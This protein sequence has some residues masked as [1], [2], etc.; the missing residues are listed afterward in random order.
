MATKNLNLGIV[1]VSRGEFNSTTIYYKDNIVQYKRGSYQVVSE[2]PIIGVPPTNDKN[3]VNPGWTLFAGTLDAQDVVNQVKDQETKSI[4]AV[5]DR[6]AEILAKSDAAEVSFNNTGTS[7]SG[8]N[9]QNALKETDNKLSE[10]ES[11][12]IY[13]VTANNDGTT[14]SSL[15]ALLSSENLSTLIPTSVRHGGMS[16]SFVQ[17][18]DNK[19]VQYFL[20][21]NVWSD[22]EADWQKL[23]LEEDVSQEVK[24]NYINLI[25][26]EQVGL[27]QS[28]TDITDSVSGYYDESGVFI[29]S[30]AFSSQKVTIDHSK[31]YYLTYNLVGASYKI[32]S[33][34][35][36][37]SNDNVIATQKLS[38][39]YNSKYL[40]KFP[41]SVAK[42]AT[43]HIP[44]NFRIYE[45]LVMD[46]LVDGLITD[47]KTNFFKSG[48]NLINPETVHDKVYSTN[49][50]YY[51]N[52]DY[53][54]SDYI[55]VE[56]NTEY[57]W[58]NFTYD[59]TYAR[60]LT[61]FDENK[62]VIS[63]VSVTSPATSPSGAKYAII[64]MYRV[65]D[66]EQPFG[67]LY[68]GKVN[69]TEFV[70]FWLKIPV[71]LIDFSHG[72]FQI[73]TNEIADGAITQEKLSTAVHINPSP[74]R[75][76]VLSS[77]VQTV[78]ANGTI[79]TPSIFGFKNISIIAHIDSTFNE[80]VLGGGK[81]SFYQV[82]FKIDG[83]NVQM[84][85]G[86][87]ATVQWTEAHGL[88]FGSHT[89]ICITTY[90][91]GTDKI[92][93]YNNE[94]EFWSHS[95]NYG[96]SG[97]IPYLT[98]NGNSAIDAELRFEMRDIN[99]KIWLFGDSY[100]SYDSD[101]RWPY[102][103]NADGFIENLISSLGGLSSSGAI[104]SFTNLLS[105]GARPSFAVWCMGMNDGSDSGN[106]PASIWLNNIQNFL[107][108]CENYGIT[109]ILATVPTVPNI[110][111]AG[112]TSWVKNSGCRY[113]DFA[114]AV[115][116]SGATTWKNWGTEKAMLS[117]DEVH[118]TAYGAKA[119]YQQAIRDFPEIMVTC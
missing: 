11:E 70:P 72:G 104:Q 55:E 43:S 117:S 32:S 60:F 88:T 89:L 17:S 58:K 8:T 9:V 84:L 110:N 91:S 38:E 44:N 40:L 103:M 85:I 21:K 93:I 5:A 75:F 20:T 14:F 26:I 94:G 111:H 27:I 24:K 28:K 54:A 39:T 98:N 90:Y 37:D 12:V 83:T 19:Y 3:I 63:E 105:T 51:N 96:N 31:I 86:S 95:V 50:H 42:F 23:N 97:G 112:K 57:Y 102:Y 101:A 76:G 46:E 10:L 99:Q 52:N 118:P 25:Q 56:P 33:I 47:R 66:I 16:I 30:S 41:S 78:A 59:S 77:G 7:F 18:S 81:D 114:K 6:E 53:C 79:Y 67:D 62:A 36:F 74:S 106:T 4:Q 64:T 68:F 119:L 22:N 109:P 87:S 108:L 92:T 29:D 34:V 73:N 48:D 65:L 116:V 113:I 49:G 2:S 13:D 115:E 15:S 61:W 69:F 1:P 80:I 100:F 71:G 82:A 35:L 107:T 45:I